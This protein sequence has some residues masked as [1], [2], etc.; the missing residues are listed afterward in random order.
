MIVS[1][2]EKTSKKFQR[3]PFWFT[4]VRGN[5]AP[6]TISSYRTSWMPKSVWKIKFSAADFKVTWGRIHNTSFSS[7]LTN[8]PNKLEG[9]IIVGCK[10][11]QLQTLYLIGAIHKYAK[12]EVLWIRTLIRTSRW[13]AFG[14]T[15]L[16]L[17]CN[18]IVNRQTGFVE[19]SH[20][21]T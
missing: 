9:F 3:W 17:L 20:S 8:C 6:S 14:R 7:Y 12:N 2:Q 15:L 4:S 10:F 18:T 16:V 13:Y 1:L 5:A 21:Q 11:F 19:H